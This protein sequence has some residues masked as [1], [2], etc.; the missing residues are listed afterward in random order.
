MN[1]IYH[2]V[3]LMLHA[4]MLLLT[5]TGSSSKFVSPSPM[6]CARC[7]KNALPLAM[8]SLL[9]TNRKDTVPL[10]EPKLP[11]Q[12]ACSKVL[13]IFI[14]FLPQLLRVLAVAHVLLRI[15]IEALRV[16]WEPNRRDYRA[17]VLAMEHGVPVDAAEKGVG[18]HARCAALHVAEPP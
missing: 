11:P 4:Y 1:I 17:P 15:D 7:L 12:P 5:L 9:I 6:L 14:I 10:F 16:T 3:N 8:N 13:K 18:F 2:F